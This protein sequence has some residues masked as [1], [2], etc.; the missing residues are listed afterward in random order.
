[1]IHPMKLTTIILVALTSNN[2]Y[3]LPACA[4]PQHDPCI[5][6]VDN[7]QYFVSSSKY[8]SVRC[9]PYD[10]GAMARIYHRTGRVPD[11]IPARNLGQ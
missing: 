1:M 9:G 7:G 4:K 10:C 3:G 5:I 11:P 6:Q 8:Y 2:P